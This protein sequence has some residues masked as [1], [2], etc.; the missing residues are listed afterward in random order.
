[1]KNSPKD[2]RFTFGLQDQVQQRDFT[3]QLKDQMGD[4]NPKKGAKIAEDRRM[5]GKFTDGT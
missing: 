2:R 5:T 1:M 4:E 3:A